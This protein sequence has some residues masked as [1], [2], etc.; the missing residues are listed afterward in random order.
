MC[1]KLIHHSGI[2]KVYVVEGGYKGAN[3]VQYLRDHGVLVE[4]VEGPKDP[5][6]SPKGPDAE[7]GVA[8]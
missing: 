6:I 5:R 3:G 7:E 2:L 8:G 1:A 4:E